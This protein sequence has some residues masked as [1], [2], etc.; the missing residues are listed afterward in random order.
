MPVTQAR[1]RTAA[2]RPCPP[3]VTCGI[4]LSLALESREAVNAVNEAAAP[5]A[6]T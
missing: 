1:W 5:M 4:N 3:D 2:Q 6:G